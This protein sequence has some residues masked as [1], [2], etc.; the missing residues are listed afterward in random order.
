MKRTGVRSIKLERGACDGM[1]PV[2]SGTLTRTRA[3]W[4]GTAFVERLG[5]WRGVLAEDDFEHV[6]DLL[7]WLGFET[8][9]SPAPATTCTAP[10]RI[11]VSASGVVACVEQWSGEETEVFGLVAAVID[12]I[13]GR[14][15]WEVV[16]DRE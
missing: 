10:N 16:P 13:A 1:F 3:S 5:S 15:H 11:F 7:V 14:I 8:W 2:Y 4:D 9:T 6:C 12:G